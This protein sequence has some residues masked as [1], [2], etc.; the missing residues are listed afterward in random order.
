MMTC[1]LSFRLLSFMDNSDPYSG[2]FYFLLVLLQMAGGWALTYS[3]IGLVVLII[4]IGL[5]SATEIA[6]FSMT[7]TDIE[8]CKRWWKWSSQNLN[9]FK[10]PLKRLLALLLIL[11]TLINIG[12]AL[13]FEHFLDQVLPE[14]SYKQ[15]R[16]LVA[17]HFWAYRLRYWKHNFIS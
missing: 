14:E 8:D 4:F 7:P 11:V 15:R 12:I 3:I 6:I 2:S 10:K 17:W 1:H 5:I 13:V 9:L 16:H